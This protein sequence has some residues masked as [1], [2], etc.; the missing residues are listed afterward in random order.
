MLL[1]LQLQKVETPP[2]ETDYGQIYVEYQLKQQAPNAGTIL[3]LHPRLEI[4]ERFGRIKA[5]VPDLAPEL[6][7]LDPEEALD[8]L[9]EWLERCAQGIR[10]RGKPRALINSYDREQR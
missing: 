1:K 4:N 3:T 2:E 8:K 6:D 7:T 5:S 10:E 9:A